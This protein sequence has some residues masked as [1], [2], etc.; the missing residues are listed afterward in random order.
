MKNSLKLLLVTTVTGLSLVFNTSCS[1]TEGAII[2]GIAG[3]AI[4]AAAANGNNHHR[5]HN[6]H[7]GHGNQGGWNNNRGQGWHG[8]G[9][10]RGHGRGHG[11]HR[12]NCW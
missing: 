2:G 1:P 12:N 6:N 3:A 8:G 5:D 10:G 11:G 7:R 4:G 9:H